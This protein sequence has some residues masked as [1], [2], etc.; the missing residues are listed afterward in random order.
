MTNLWLYSISLYIRE[1]TWMT[2]RQASML[3]AIKLEA[4]LATITTN[5]GIE[6]EG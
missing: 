3:V 6:I 1:Q 5:H 4:S 2:L